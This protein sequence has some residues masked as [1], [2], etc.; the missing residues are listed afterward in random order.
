M[1]H[2]LKITLNDSDATQ[3][4]LIVE[5]N[6]IEIDILVDADGLVTT[7]QKTNGEAIGEVSCDW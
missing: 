3:G 4:R 1:K 7:V 6:G 2:E 5:C